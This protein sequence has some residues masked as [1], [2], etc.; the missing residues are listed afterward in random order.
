MT[1]SRKGP[2]GRV[3]LRGARQTSAPTRPAPVRG[4]REGGRTIARRIATQYRH[5]GLRGVVGAAAERGARLWRDSPG[6]DD[7]GVLDGVLEWLGGRE[8]FRI[9]QIGAYIGDSAND[10]LTRFLHQQRH[11]DDG[12]IAVL[13]E[14]VRP[15]FEQL[16]GNYSALPFARFENVAVAEEPGE[17]D[18][19]RL[20]VDPAAHGF[21]AWM[22][23]LGS[24]RAH[25]MTELWDAYE[26]EPRL[27]DFYLA[28]R[29]V[30]RVECVTFQQLLDRHGIAELDLLQVDTEG[31]D[32]EI[33]RTVDFTRTRPSF[34][35][36]ERVLLG[37]DEAACRVLMRNAGYVLFDWKQDTLC[38]RVA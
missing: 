37:P 24:L 35:N 30:D 12:S 22:S 18:F 16:V 31:Y 25:R 1:V 21:P 32:Y 38:V 10:P 19:Y 27:R 11:R 29:V 26:R 23:Q 2:E 9:V 8:R 20:G 5:S 36:Y 6:G 13:V 34:V 4:A 14:P 17:R 28:H 3:V 33:L 7:T 15:H